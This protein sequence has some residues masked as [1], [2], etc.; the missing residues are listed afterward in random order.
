MRDGKIAVSP[1]HYVIKSG[2]LLRT[3]VRSLSTNYFGGL[4]LTI[5]K[6]GRLALCGTQGSTVIHDLR[7]K[8]GKIV[9]DLTKGQMTRISGGIGGRM[10]VS[11]RSVLTAADVIRGKQSERMIIDAELAGSGTLLIAIGSRRELVLLSRDNHGFIG[12]WDLD[13]GI[14]VASA[15]EA[16]GPGPVTLGALGKLK[17]ELPQHI[18]VL[19]APSLEHLQLDE[20]LQVTAA[21]IDGEPLFSGEHKMMGSRGKLLVLP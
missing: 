19:T 11:E 16:L 5:E 10:H 4:S 8:G 9:L 15:R 17:V 14:L 7:L 13:N 2:G 3:E 20:D 21:I 12:G 6:G 1:I 18:G